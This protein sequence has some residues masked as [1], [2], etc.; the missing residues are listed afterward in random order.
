MIFDF[1]SQPPNTQPPQ[2]HYLVRRHLKRLK[3]VWQLPTRF[4]LL[5]P[6]FQLIVTVIAK[7]CTACGDIMCKLQNDH[8]NPLEA[9]SKW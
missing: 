3:D 5:F 9:E 7:C 2:I 4:S 6:L 8:N 1:P